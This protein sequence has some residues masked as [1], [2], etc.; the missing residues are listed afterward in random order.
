ML[1]DL[2]AFLLS[3]D[4]PVASFLAYLL[5][6]TF[7]WDYCLSVKLGCWEEREGRVP[8]GSNTGRESWQQG[9]Q[10]PEQ[11]DEAPGCSCR[12]PCTRIGTG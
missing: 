11:K 7:M 12:V 6:E 1:P 10:Q 2:V 3:A 5:F 8:V 9:Q 4:L